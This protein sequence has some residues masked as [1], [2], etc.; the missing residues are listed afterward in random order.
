MNP[1]EDTSPNDTS[2]DISANPGYVLGQLA[3]AFAT[4]QTHTDPEVRARA[5]QK[6]ATWIQTLQ[7]MLSGALQIGSRTPVASTPAWATL[8]VVKGGFATGTLL[9]GGALQ[10]HE[11]ELLRRLPSVPVGT[12]RTAITSYYLSDIGL[13]ML[14]QMLAS[15]SYH[16]QVPEEGALLAVTWLLSYGHADQARALLDELMPYMSQLRF[17]PVPAAQPHPVSALVHR[18]TVGEIIPELRR[19]RVPTEIATEREAVTIWAPLY[20]RVVALFVETVTGPL[21][22]LRVGL[23]GTPVR[24]DEG[25]FIVDGGWPCQRYANDWRTRAQ[26]ALD[27]CHRLQ[28]IHQLCHKPKRPSENFAILR[29]Y[30]EQYTADPRQLSSRDVGKIRAILAAINTKRGLPGSERCQKLRRAQRAQV[31]RPTPAE[32]APVLIARLAQLPQ[33]E[34]VA[35]LDEVL[36]P[37]TPD[38]AARFRLPAHQPLSP[39]LGAKLRRCLDA[40]VETL[41]EQ[42]VIPSGEVLARV[43]P[44][45][46]AQVRAAGIAD[47]EL[48]RLYGVI[49]AA[50]RRRRSLL[51]LNLEHQVRIEELPWVAAINAFRTDDLSAREQVRQ[52]LEQVVTLVISAFPQQILPNKLLQEI[53][54]LAEG[55]GLH[56]PIVDELAADIFMGDFSEKYLRAAQQAGRLLAGTLYERYYGIDY[57]QVQQI[58]DVTSLGYGAPTSPAFTRLCYDRAGT[59][60]SGGRWSVARNGTVIEQEQILTTHNLAVLFQELRLIDTLGPQ[61]DELARRCFAWICRR[62]QQKIDVWQPRL[63]MLKN[64]AYAW[65]Q[66]VFF[67]ALM[68]VG[69]VETFLGWAD[70][71]LARQRPDFQARFRPALQGLALTPTGGSLDDQDQSGRAGEPRRFLGWSTERHWLLVDQ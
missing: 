32:L 8:E 60:P 45:I 30:L 19:I 35:V 71:H 14:R 67:L 28:A 57:A 20:D 66:M 69:A 44:Q 51:L 9:A 7:G 16:I 68:P 1:S 49:Y 38:E 46:T 21:P 52:T 24:S 43:I 4:S 65:R 23:D 36:V 47:P 13:D 54:A 70:D 39:V 55:A 58:D 25:R 10:P 59:A 31:A 27:D 50:F 63:R 62:Q 2:T 41:V 42:G 26:T 34:G 61:L 53:R 5:E 64:S 37:I 6:I 33:D 29:A 11:D 48:R 22:A 18:Q 17:Y 40:P 12:E 3:Q 56:L 15:G